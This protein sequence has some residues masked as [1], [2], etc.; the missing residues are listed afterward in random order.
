MNIAIPSTGHAPSANFVSFLVALFLIAVFGILIALTPGA[1]GQSGNSLP[2]PEPRP[3]PAPGVAPAHQ[4]HS[5]LLL[6]LV[7]SAEQADRA[8]AEAA[9]AALERAAGGSPDANYGVVVLMASTPEEE[10]RVNDLMDSWLN[11]EHHSVRITDLRH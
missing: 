10:R 3:V 1:G 8:Y 5:L 11:V 6:Y 7:D 2:A 9:T 4:G